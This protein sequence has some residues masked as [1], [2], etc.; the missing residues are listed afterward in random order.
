MRAFSEAWKGSLPA[1]QQEL[2]Q[3]KHPPGAALNQLLMEVGVQMLQP[4]HPSVGNL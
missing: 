4:S 2:P 3:M 1:S